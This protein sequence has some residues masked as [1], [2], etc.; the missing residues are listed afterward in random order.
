MWPLGILRHPRRW[1]LPLAA[2]T[3][4]LAGL[5]A[6]V[7]WFLRTVNDPLAKLHWQSA[8]PTGAAPVPG[9]PVPP[10][11]P[12]PPPRTG[13]VRQALPPSCSAQ[14]PVLQSPPARPEAELVVQVGA[15]LEQDG[16]LRLVKQATQAGFAVSIARRTTSSGKTIF[17]VQVDDVLERRSAAQLATDIKRK[18]PNVDPIFVRRRH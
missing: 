11:P 13:V 3:L 8:R 4:L 14:H 10:A 1:I 18:M 5:G 2:V 9:V 7:R 17:R 16:A 6:G 12:A 15:F